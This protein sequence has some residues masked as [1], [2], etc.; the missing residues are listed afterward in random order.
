MSDADLIAAKRGQTIDWV[1]AT[2]T[3]TV[4][5]P[6][7]GEAYAAFTVRLLPGATWMRRA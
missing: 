6:H 3:A 4:G 7:P 5:T 2:E 1:K